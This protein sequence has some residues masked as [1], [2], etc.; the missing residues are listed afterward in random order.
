MSPAACRSLPAAPCMFSRALT[1]FMHPGAA[2][3]SSLVR[4]C[5]RGRV[6]EVR[7]AGTAPDC[8]GAAEGP[9]AQKHAHGS[10]CLENSLDIKGKQQ[11]RWGRSGG[12][13][14]QE[15]ES[16]GQRRRVAAVA[17]CERRVA[18]S[19]PAATPSITGQHRPPL[20]QAQGLGA[21]LAPRQRALPAAAQRHAVP[22]PW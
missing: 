14:E 5:S 20:S 11:S 12:Q 22:G 17:S 16:G 19:D 9:E 21:P 2:S 13:R 8:G 6:G 3:P 18:P 4:P 1:T 10:R 7:E 15:E